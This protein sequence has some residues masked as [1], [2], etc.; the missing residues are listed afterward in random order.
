MPFLNEK[1]TLTSNIFLIA[2]TNI[3]SKEKSD[4]GRLLLENVWPKDV[5][6]FFLMVSALKDPKAVFE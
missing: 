2:I 6:I 1:S 3:I 4:L 5:E